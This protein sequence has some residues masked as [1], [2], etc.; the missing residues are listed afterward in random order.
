MKYYVDLMI[1]GDDTSLLQD[2]WGHTFFRIHLLCISES[3]IGN[4]IGVSFPEYY[5]NEDKKIGFIGDKIR[6]FCNSQDGLSSLANDCALFLSSGLLNVPDKCAFERFIRIQPKLSNSK[7]RRFEK[8][9]P[10]IEYNR[11]ESPLP[12]PKIKIKSGSSGQNFYFYIKKDDNLDAIQENDGLYGLN[13][14]TPVF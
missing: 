5:C 11:T 1:N 8:R 6:V 12:Y 2:N 10:G 3:K 4:K 7:K 13:H 9:N 14:T